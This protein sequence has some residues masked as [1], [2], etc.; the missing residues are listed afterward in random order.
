[1]RNDVQLIAVQTSSL[2][3]LGNLNIFVASKI[4]LEYLSPLF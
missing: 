2:L 1:M 4:G 3:W